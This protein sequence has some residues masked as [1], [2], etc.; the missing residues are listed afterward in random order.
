MGLGKGLGAKVRLA[1]DTVDVNHAGALLNPEEPV[2]SPVSSPGVGDDPVVGGARLAPAHNLHIFLSEEEIFL[3]VRLA[4][5]EVHWREVTLQDLKQRI[6]F[7]QSTLYKSL[8]LLQDSTLG[9][10]LR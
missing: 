6:M 8:Y 4:F 10:Y 7:F 5:F 9:L 1:C 3:H 2:L